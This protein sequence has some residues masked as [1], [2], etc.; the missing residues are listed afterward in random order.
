[1]AD[2]SILVGLLR[3]C[4]CDG[5]DCARHQLRVV[6][7]RFVA[8]IGEHRKRRLAARTGRELRAY[9]RRWIG[10]AINA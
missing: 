2:H 10:P 1:M 5:E 3:R 7:H 4:A 8:D 9:L 6:K